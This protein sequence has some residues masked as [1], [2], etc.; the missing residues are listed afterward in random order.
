MAKKNKKTNKK[1]KSKKI[2]DQLRDELDELYD[3]ESEFDTDYEDIDEFDSFKDDEDKNYDDQHELNQDDQFFNSNDN[4]ED[5]FEKPSKKKSKKSGLDK[6]AKK[7]KYHDDY[8]D[9]HYDDFGMDFDNQEDLEFEPVKKTDNK[10]NKTDKPKKSKKNKN[11][12]TFDKDFDKRYDH[13]DDFYPPEDGYYNED[14]DFDQNPKSDKPKKSKKNKNVETF[15]KDFD[16][17][18]DHEDDFYPPEDGYYNEDLDFD[19]NPKSDKPKKS[20]KNKNVET[21][22]KDFDEPYDHED[23]FYPPEDEYYN[24][25]LDFDQNPEF[26][27]PK[28]TKTEKNKK[29]ETKKSK[30]QNKND[31][32]QDYYGDEFFHDENPEYIDDYFTEPEQDFDQIEKQKSNKKK[33][34]KPKKS[35]KNKDVQETYDDYPPYDDESVYGYDQDY[36][37][38]E[39]ERYEDDFDYHEEPE[40]EE[41]KKPK[42]KGGFLGFGKRRKNDYE[43]DYYDDR[44]YGHED[45][46]YRDDYYDDD[47]DDWEERDYP[48]EYD[49]DYPDRRKSSREDDLYDQYTIGGENPYLYQQ[50]QKK[51]KSLFWSLISFLI[52]S[53]VLIASGLTAYLI[54]RN[55]VSFNS[56]PNI[57]TQYMVDTSSTSNQA[58]KYVAERS[59]SL[60]FYL[61]NG[62]S[63]RA[64]FGTGWI[65]NKEK[66]SDTYY[67]ATNIHVAAA[68]TYGN[69]KVSDN[70]DFT[71]YSLSSAAVSYI[72]Y[73]SNTTP[74][75][76]SGNLNDVKTSIPEVV[77]LADSS[78]TSSSFGKA[79]PNDT[80]SNYKNSLDFA[81]LKYGFSTT[82]LTSHVSSSNSAVQTSI[83]NFSNWLK[84]GYGA[85]PTQ[86]YST[87]VSGLNNSNPIQNTTSTNEFYT[88]KYYMGG[89][90]NL[91]TGG[92]A[93]IEWV[94]LSNFPIATPAGGIADSNITTANYLAHASGKSHVD[95]S[96]EKWKEENKIVYYNSTSSVATNYVNVG[97]NGLFDA[98][99]VA[100]ASG[101]MVVAN[102]SDD[103]NS[104]NSSFKV[105][106]IYWGTE[107]FNFTTTYQTVG[108][109]S[110]LNIS[111]YQIN[112]TTYKG[113]DVFD[114]ATKAITSKLASGK[115]LEYSYTSKNSLVTSNSTVTNP[116]TSNNIYSYFSTSWNSIDN[117]YSQCL[118]SI[119]K[120]D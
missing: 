51:K 82:N 66:D 69:K 83:Q 29:E 119:V 20:K 22:D 89:Y 46:K 96:D 88:R 49:E 48:D 95:Q 40:F 13:E 56:N 63:T 21:F 1:D 18:Y 90:P 26:E 36:H 60:S 81:I 85:N 71:G 113:Y 47:D 97:L 73:S 55:R 74:I 64:V 33:T 72:N 35:K 109:G 114:D 39:G 17:R 120:N 28:K 68:L 24:R 32:H 43:D 61:S 42:G 104:T 2:D 98:T 115:S 108:V 91:S 86:F 50:P 34:D 44:D 5:S 62:S 25:D 103:A 84:N 41:T 76:S 54:I 116:T 107:V 112:G 106:G 7:D 101:S 4:N 16:K 100:G 118:Y 10:K 92:G 11:I 9:K 53:I 3:D 8:E 70:E 93:K 110:L 65:F 78:N 59:L 6:K 99:S 102:L 27:Q 111:D 77:Y 38:L 75:Y 67:I 37:S 30:K 87:P 19:Q 58:M 52:L 31:D 12:E 105:V 15:D 57:T 117:N 79:Y 80:S 45:A 14:L 94:G 23:D